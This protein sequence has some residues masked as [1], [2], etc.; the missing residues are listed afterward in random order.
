MEAAAPVEEAFAEAQQKYEA[1]LQLAAERLVTYGDVYMDKGELVCGGAAWQR[2]VGG[3]A[4]RRF[5]L[6]PP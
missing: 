6:P 5:L 1:A 4:G 2:R 3:A